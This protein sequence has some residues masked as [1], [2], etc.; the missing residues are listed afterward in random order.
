MVPI[1]Y[2]PDYH[3]HLGQHVFP[4]EKY[5]LIHQQ[6]LDGGCFA[7]GDFHSPDEAT[8]EQL[9]LVHTREYL[10]KVRTG[11]FTWEEILRLEISY[12]PELIRAC[13]LSAGGT[14]RACEIA[15]QFGVVV[16]LGGGFHHAYAGHGEGFCVLNDIAAGIA[17][18]LKYGHAAAALVVDCD[19]HQG[20]GTASIFQ[21][22][23]RV[24]TLSLHQE[25]NYPIPKE[26][27][28]LD[29]GLEDGTRDDA[30]LEALQT[31]LDRAFSSRRPDLIVYVAGADPYEQDQL[32]GL[33]LTL[34]GLRRRDEI[35]LER[36]AAEACPI[37][38]T[39][40]G[41]Y[42]HNVSDTVAIHINTIMTA[43]RQYERQ[44][45]NG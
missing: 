8:D 17:G 42:A 15:R 13:L 9:A 39:L 24:F 31:G 1:F 16:N 5:A 10:H 35:V 45:K 44:R 2:T 25:N 43:Q 4:S 14:I 38:V 22:D 23:P 30:Y 34:D 33:S 26:Q 6:L 20:N 29:I 27:S 18:S 19:V 41:G 37:V 7:P 11:D 21:S 40:A 3:L 32:G 28:D 12:S 36:A